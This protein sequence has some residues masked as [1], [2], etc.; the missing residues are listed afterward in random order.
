MVDPAR[1]PPEF[2]MLCMVAEDCCMSPGDMVPVPARFGGRVLEA[3]RRAALREPAAP[4][5]GDALSDPE[6]LD[7][8]DFHQ[9][10]YDLLPR[11]VG[12]ASDR[13]RVLTLLFRVN[14][15]RAPRGLRLKG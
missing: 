13:E 3:L 15:K 2:V 6:L 4:L 14:G 9:L 11:L 5:D 7:V 1:F 8:M 10:P 12:R